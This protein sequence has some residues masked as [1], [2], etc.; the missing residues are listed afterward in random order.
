MQSAVKKE[1]LINLSPDATT[2]MNTTI[3]YQSLATT[4][5]MNS[6]SPPLTRVS[7]CGMFT[8]HKEL[9]WS[10]LSWR[11]ALRRLADEIYE[12]M[13][14]LTL[15]QDF[16]L[17]IPNNAGDDWANEKQ[18]YSWTEN[19]AFLPDKRI[20]L[21]AMLAKR[22]LKL[23]QINNAGQLIFNHSAIWA[24][25]HKCDA[26]SEKIALLAFFT[27]GQTP[28]VS[29]FIE[30]KYAN[31]T[32]PRTMFRD[33]KSLWLAT[34]RVKSE[35]LVGKETFLPMK[36]HPELTRFL[37]RYLLIIH[38][39]EAEL[40]KIV[41]GEMQYHVY[42]EYLWTKGGERTTP[43]QMR[44]SILKFNTDYCGV[45]AGTRDYRQICVQMGRTFLGSEFEIQQEEMD[46]LAYQAGHS[47]TIARLRYATEE[48]Q[49]A[50]MSTDLLLRFGRVSEAWWEH[51]GFRPGYSPLLP[52]RAR[53]ELREAAFTAAQLQPAPAPAPA[54]AVDNQAIILAIIAAVIAEFQKLQGSM[55]TQ[56]KQ[57]ITQVLP[58]AHH[59]SD[60][61]HLPPPH[62]APPTTRFS[63]PSPPPPP[64]SEDV[65][66]INSDEEENHSSPLTQGHPPVAP[67]DMTDSIYV[68]DSAGPE[69]DQTSLHP[70]HHADLHTDST[71]HDLEAV[72]DSDVDLNALLALHSPD[73]LSPSF[74]S[75]E[76]EK[77]VQL[78]VKHHHSFVAVLPASDRGLIYTLPAFNS[79]EE[80][81]RRLSYIIVSS[82]SLLK[83]HADRAKQLNIKCKQWS[84]KNRNV[85][86]DRHRLVFV[87]TLSHG[88]SSPKFKEYVY[89]FLTLNYILIDLGWLG[90][91]LNMG[92][93]LLVGFWMA[94]ISSSQMHRF[95]AFM[96][97]Q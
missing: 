52:L 53:Q 37:E 32:R 15:H 71:T 88:A 33:G 25:L 51:A 39:V 66:M 91:G 14:E 23:A 43:E 5:A 55:D 61:G 7:E 26:L 70:I 40:V 80:A 83:D 93:M 72:S 49:I 3:D 30:H 8:Y 50:S 6:S 57:A 22:E 86:P 77:A 12:E 21:A 31:S 41:Q 67:I 28:R 4:I 76:Q 54:P 79:K 59:H 48:G 81:G 95:T 74:T 69:A 11:T 35:T 20:L 1:A 27:A 34:R 36:C 82:S 65:Q 19:H 29:E 94:Q 97:M 63:P 24:F 84:D 58:I 64:S 45:A 96:I 89:F 92:S 73:A 60:I 78:A 13:D 2:P 16:G 87:N 42:K 46:T 17:D 68:E 47:V 85:N 56:I 44:A 62:H 75:P 18:G 10:V 38:P 9:T 90:I